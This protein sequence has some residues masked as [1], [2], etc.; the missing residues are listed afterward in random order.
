MYL[1]IIVSNC[2]ILKVF[3]ISFVQW[4]GLLLCSEPNLNK[5]KVNINLK[6]SIIDPFKL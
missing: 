5:L 3:F 1:H 6:L 2:G 4:F